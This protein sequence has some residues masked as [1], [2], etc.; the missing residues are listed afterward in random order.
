MKLYCECFAAKQEC[1]RLCRCCDCK[2]QNSSEHAHLQKNA[3]NNG[4]TNKII[5]QDGTKEPKGCSCRKSF[6]VKKYCE[7]FQERVLCGENCKCVDC[8]NNE[9]MT[10]RSVLVNLKKK[11][12]TT[13]SN[14]SLCTSENMLDPIILSQNTEHL[15]HLIEE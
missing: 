10:N 14:G 6:C 4:N 3:A 1:N 5:K 2:N 12:S 7:C 9:S 13:N 8:Q 15:Q 11:G